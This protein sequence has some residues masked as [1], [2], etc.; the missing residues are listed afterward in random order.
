MHLLTYDSYDVH[1]IVLGILSVVAVFSLCHRVSETTST[2]C[3]PHLVGYIHVYAD[4]YTVPRTGRSPDKFSKG[5]WHLFCP[6]LGGISS[7][8]YTCGVTMH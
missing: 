4:I 5:S 1:E 7:I 2:Y 6:R 8:L 3:G